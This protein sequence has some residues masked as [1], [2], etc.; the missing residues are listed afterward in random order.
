MEEESK[1]GMTGR[2]IAFL[3]IAAFF[4]VIV[5]YYTVMALIAPAVKIARLN[6][7]Y[8]YKPAENTTIDERIFSDSAFVRLN[9]E[10][11]FNQAC[12]KL[13]ESDSLC[14]VLNLHD[15]LAILEINGVGV[16]TARLSSISVSKVF[17][18]AD[19]YAVTSIL[20]APFT[21]SKDYSTIRK[22]PLMIKTAP[23]DTSEYK[24]DILPDTAKVEAV[25]YMLEMENGFRLYVYQQNDDEKKGGL[26]R[27]F[28]DVNDR[29]KNIAAIFG[30]IFAFRVPDYHPAIRVRMDR[31]DARIIY[32]ALP[33]N[34]QIAVYR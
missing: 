33:R 8:G 13:A 6:E 5:L 2:K 10:K 27:Y 34:G 14:L 25:N 21:V 22:E 32:R 23:K 24:P 19:E 30:S 4:L 11:A 17:N 1:K 15:S 29:L 31:K 7:E 3:S 28:F 12:I 26:R 18:N 20:S 16:H 9:R